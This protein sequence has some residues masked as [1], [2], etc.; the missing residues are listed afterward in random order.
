MAKI[1]VFI[2]K[3]IVWLQ[4]K[5]RWIVVGAFAALFLL[6]LLSVSLPT[7][8]W[9]PAVTTFVVAVRAA[10]ARLTQVSGGAKN[11]KTYV[12]FGAVIV[13]YV[14]QTLGIALPISY[15][16]IYQFLAGFQMVG[17]GDAVNKL[18]VI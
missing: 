11:W 14:C 8:W 5:K 1:V 3:V 2:G 4:G 7:S 15:D 12:S 16:Y 17:I 10:L 13:C 18:K 9:I 6:Q